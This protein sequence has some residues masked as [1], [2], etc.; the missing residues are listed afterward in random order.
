V[1]KL[2]WL[3]AICGV[4]LYP[5]AALLAGRPWAQLELF[6]MTPEPTALATLGLLLASASPPSRPLRW[7]LVTIPAL[8]LLVGAATLWL[9]AGGAN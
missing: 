2:G 4:L 9:V 5:L 1:R 3:L 6:G 7:L 8:S